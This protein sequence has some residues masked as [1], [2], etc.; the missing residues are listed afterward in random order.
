MRLA[1]PST[2]KKKPEEIS[3]SKRICIVGGV[4]GGASFAARLRRLDEAAEIVMFEKGE[5]ISFANCGLPYYIGGV[6]Q[7]RDSLLIQTPTAF[8]TRFNVD[9]R[10]QCAVTG[11]D[12]SKKSITV[13]CGA[14]E[15]LEKYDALV[16]SPGASPIRP[17]IKG[18]ESPNVV[19]LRSIPDTDRIKAMVDSKKAGSAVIIGGGFIGLEMAENLRALGIEVTIVEL[20]DQVFAPADR[21]MAVLLHQHLTANG[22]HLVLGDGLKE[23]APTA[24]GSSEV[25]L[26]G[27]RRLSADMVVLAIGVRPDTDF[28][29]NS[30]IALTGRGAIVVDEHLRTS[31][32]DVYAVGDAVETVDFIS[33]RKVTIPLAGPA[34]RQGRIAAD[35]M[36]GIPSTYKGTLGTA[37]C[38]IFGMTAAVTGMSEKTVKQLGIPYQK[39]YTHS[40]SHAGYYPG[41]SMMSIKLLFD[42]QSGKILG[43]QIIG[44][45]GV[46]KRIDV[47]AAAIKGGLTTADACDLELAYAPPYGSAKDPVNMAGYVAQNIIEG[48]MP[49]FFA[50][51]VTGIDPARHLLLDVRTNGEHLRGAIEGSINIPVDE[52]RSRISEL[53]MTKEIMVYCQIGLRGYIATRILIQNGFRVRNLSGGYRTFSLV[54]G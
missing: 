9:V 14:Q 11:I 36:C 44:H 8:K 51:D 45:D 39:S 43:C 49:V 27:G 54:K 29:K 28:V 16:L 5:Y 46:D 15:T 6:I 3:M 21:E 25:L 33:G 2:K 34:N 20:L 23:I 52:L 37:V 22:V 42:P 48:R 53:D 13:R 40:Q 24:D 38:K 19:S 4:A 50:E 10:I 18:I 1:P 32:P 31:A 47:L 12:T 7:N 17:P 41:A 35:N 30:G 26:A